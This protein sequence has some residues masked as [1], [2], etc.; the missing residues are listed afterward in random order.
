MSYRNITELPGG[1]KGPFEI[2]G[3]QYQANII[4]F[5]CHTLPLFFY[6]K[7]KKSCKTIITSEKNWIFLLPSFLSPS[8]TISLPGSFTPRNVSGFLLNF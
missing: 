2:S 1:S 3:P 5:L 7:K 6:L 8:S 4:S